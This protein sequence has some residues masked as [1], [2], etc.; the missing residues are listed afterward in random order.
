M[1]MSRSFIG[2]WAGWL[3]VGL[4]V[5]AF[6]V[7]ANA[8]RG[9][10]PPAS[11][12]HVSALVRQLGSPRF[13]ERERATREL[14]GLGI[15][16]K[17][18]LSAAVNDPDA[19]LRVRA[20][21]VLATVTESDFQN[22]L[23]A[24]AADYDGSRKLSLPGW[25][26]FARLFGASHQARRLFVEMARH[27]PQ[28]LEAYAE[29][30]KAAS[31]ALGQR[32]RELLDEFMQ[33]SSREAA[34]PVGTLACLLL[35]GS[36]DEVTL[37]EQVGVQLYTWMVYQPTFSKN[38]RGGPWSG[39]MKKLLGQW[40]IKD[41]SPSATVQNLIFAAMYELKPEGLALA[42]K[43]L[44]SETPTPQLR[45]FAL[46]AIGR[47]GGK[48]HLAVVEKFL[49]DD[50]TCGA[51][52]M[53]NPPR[54]VEVQVRDAALAVLIGLTDQKARDY[55]TVSAQ[56]SPQSMFQVPALGFADA[57]KREAALKHWAQWRAAHPGP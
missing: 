52:Q 51:L 32:C 48:E 30:G 37:D 21:Q 9:A 11:P 35:V 22:R 4:S 23:E 7:P 46:L 36:A 1:T 56:S 47:F 17:D 54:Q 28:L 41:S 31:D 49:S 57:A 39:I 29:G 33:V 40:I 12:D 27:E 50:T 25:E 45:Q 18:A 3:A 38:A 53:S 6:A 19:E 42:G 44:A 8:A 26:R 34:F 2:C 55:G 24:F 43:T 16:A 10:N 20:R 15:V 13:A 5:A 14:T